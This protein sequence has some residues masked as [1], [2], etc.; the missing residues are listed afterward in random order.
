VFRTNRPV[1]NAAFY[2]REKELGRLL[3]LTADLGAGAPSWLAILGPRK[4]GKTSL[5]LECARRSTGKGIVIVSID[6]TE[7]A[8][9]STEF[10]RRYALRVIDAVFAAE[11]GESP[12]AL[13]LSPD[14]YRAAIAGS[15]RFARLDATTRRIVL[16]IP[17]T[18]IDSAMIR[19]WL[20]LPERIA[21]ALGLGLLVAID[22][23]QELGVLESKRAGI[24]PYRVMRSLWQRQKR[25]AYVISGSGR[26]MLQNLV[27]AKSSPFF[28]HFELMTLGALPREAAVRLLV[29]CSPSHRRIPEALAEA[30]VDLVG[31][32]PFYLQMLGDAIVR[33][34]PPY[35][36][37]TLKAVVQDLLF[38]PTGRLSLYFENELERLV[39]RSTNLLAVLES[40]AGGP[41]RL[42]KIARSIGAPPGQA[43]GYV[44]RL[45]DA[46]QRR[47]DG[48]YEL[49]DATFGLWL[50]WR[51]PG[52]SVVPMTVLGDDAER[53]V[54]AHLARCGFE[55]I[56]QSRASRGAFD[57]L[58]TRGAHQ[59]GVQVK[60][61]A[62][63]IRFP[64]AAWSRMEA[65]G[66]RFGWRWVVAAVS[67][68][69]GVTLLDPARA[70]RGKAV[71]LDRRAAIEN[72]V[73]WV[74]KA[75]KA[76]KASSV[77]RR[78]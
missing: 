65:D 76:D 17:D 60:L 5:I 13:A 51:R 18:P 8:P 40:L 62:L 26:S 71:S 44:T 37:A 35:E 28:Q 43:R 39:G 49:D 68:E 77:G 64:R 70:T 66:E 69:H 78:H 24:E 25:T 6:T 10:F 29:E 30:A 75:D 15:P 36:R 33:T 4:I 45:G 55:L 21:E 32:R 52:G 34:D 7:D 3:Q 72:I 46:V 19:Q 74:D 61:A 73:A 38:S 14:A 56:Y 47:A 12:E 20:D 9:L 54:A 11:L 27:T 50:R 41:K 59:L 58:A 57:L 23:F 53:A 42:S 67:P 1:T 63:P 22:E 2:D 48:S 31:A 16:A